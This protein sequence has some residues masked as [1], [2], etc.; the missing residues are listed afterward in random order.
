MRSQWQSR[1]S[2]SAIDCSWAL[3]PLSMVLFHGLSFS[4]WKRLPGG[5]H[6][7]L[8]IWEEWSMWEKHLSD[9]SYLLVP[10]ALH[11]KTQQ[12]ETQ[13]AIHSS[14]YLGCS[15]LNLP[16][17][18][19]WIIPGLQVGC[20]EHP[21]SPGNPRAQICFRRS[22]LSLWFFPPCQAQTILLIS[23]TFRK[24]LK[25]FWQNSHGICSSVFLNNWS[26]SVGVS[27]GIPAT[28]DVS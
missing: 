21:H 11:G 10:L 19:A 3:V 22:P 16:T 28:L 4:N 9:K 17:S 6:G 27:G 23:V 12:C 25:S 26:R 8:W 13:Q 15:E 5:S 24:R 1:G 2:W 14:S 20:L 7:L 18:F